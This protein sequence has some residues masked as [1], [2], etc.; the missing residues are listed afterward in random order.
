MFEK[1]IDSHCPKTDLKQVNFRHGP[2]L[3]EMQLTQ[4]GQDTHLHRG[5]EHTSPEKES[6]PCWIVR[7]AAALAVI[8]S[9]DV[10]EDAVN[11]WKTYRKML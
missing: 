3:E 2:R 1:S 8:R 9:N 10:F 11:S 7:R 6:R 4:E 5:P